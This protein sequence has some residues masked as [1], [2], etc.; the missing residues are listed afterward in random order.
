MALGLIVILGIIDTMTGYEASFAVFYLI[1]VSLVSYF[2]NRSIGLFIAVVSAA[3]WLAADLAAGHVYTHPITSLWNA[4][5][6]LG[7]FSVVVVLLA[8]LR[9]AFEHEQKLAR[10]DFLTGAANA[11]SF[12]EVAN[13]EIKRSRR[14]HH[15]F[16]VAH[17]DVDN[18]KAVN[19]TLGHS[20]GD[21]LLRAIV[22]LIQSQLRETDVLARLGGDEFALLLPETDQKAAQATLEKIKKHLMDEVEKQQWPISFSIGV[23]T[24]VDA[25]QSVDVLLKLADALTYEGK[26]SGKNTI[27][28]GMMPAQSVGIT[29]QTS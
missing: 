14:Y 19:D 2:A 5:T 4:G 11:R 20:A 24:C 12:Y 29:S 3:V 28:Q 1:P 8:S 17:M 16:S 13:M 6:R 26:N 7:S 10:S 9:Q 23:L 27:I 15:P 18:F 21:D 25:P 22:N